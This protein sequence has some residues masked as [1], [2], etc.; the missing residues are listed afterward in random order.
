MTN[1]RRSFRSR[2]VAAGVAVALATGLATGALAAGDATPR[3]EAPRIA[4]LA[5]VG[6]PATDVGRAVAAARREAGPGAGRATVLRADGT[7]D[8]QAQAAALATGR[9]AVIAGVG[10]AG[11]AAVGQAAGAQIGGDTR[12]VEVR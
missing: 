4:V 12:W 9:Y 6:T 5:T 10:D 1:D 8:A 11:R 2:T 7:L 3:T